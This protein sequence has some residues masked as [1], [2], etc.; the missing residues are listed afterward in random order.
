[1]ANKA[2]SMQTLRQIL[3]LRSQGKGIRNISGLLGVSRNTVKK[4]LF[5]LEASG[6]V[7]EQALALKDLDLQSLY[8]EKFLS[9]FLLVG[10]Y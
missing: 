6:L 7:F 8:R 3:R 4:Y 1:M 5:N 10:R 9:Q 2:I